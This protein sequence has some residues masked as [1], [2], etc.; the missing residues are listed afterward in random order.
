VG[1]SPK[2]ALEILVRD[3]CGGELI[4]ARPIGSDSTDDDSTTKGIGYGEALLLEVQDPGGA[5]SRLVFHTAKPNSFGHDLRADR[6]AEMLVAFDTFGE[7][8]SHVE[9]IDVGALGEDGE[10]VSLS[11]AG[12]FYLLTRFAEGSIYAG[13]LRR[14]ADSGATGV[15]RERSAG[16][17]S[18]LAELHR[19]P[20]DNDELYRRSLR[21]LV[22][23]G[24]G[25]FGLV[26][27]FPADV[28]G[29][30]ARRLQAI[31]TRCNEWRWRLRDRPHRL[32]RIH[33]DFHPFNIVFDD[34]GKLSLLD[35][36]RGSFGDPAN[37]ASCLAINY[38]FFALG[39]PGGWQRGLRD[40]WFGFWRTYA[41]ES[42]DAELLEVV[43]PYLAWR[44]LVLANPLW[45][46]E[47]GAADRGS[48]LD[49]IEAALDAPRF[50][51][52]SVERMFS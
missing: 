29:A 26:D 14:V 13:D 12:E 44:G 43:A 38:P 34:A 37:D 19:E 6:A 7:I 17:A 51:P 8:P 9:A 27:N 4:A 42:R 33:G 10:L 50:D 18:Y 11:R 40:L 35:A 5:I 39:H 52:E 49:L 45:Y 20:L 31:E 32:R 30:P 16:L 21:D 25:I 3:V 46:P 48:V 24:E 47:L 1:N 22:G 28:D 36:S 15:D 41:A 23:S 2:R